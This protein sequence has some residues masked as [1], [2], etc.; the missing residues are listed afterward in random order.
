MKVSITTWGP[1]GEVEV[2]RTRNWK[3]TVLEPV[4]ILLVI[5]K[6]DQVT[7]LESNERTKG[8]RHFY[9]FKIIINLY[10][11]YI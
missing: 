9:F 5:G 4:P 10:I 7:V 2:R 6:K 8:N 11:S 1:T 3:I